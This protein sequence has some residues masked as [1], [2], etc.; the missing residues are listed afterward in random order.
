MTEKFFEQEAAYF[1]CSCGHPVAY[2]KIREPDE[3]DFDDA[4]KKQKCGKCGAE[5]VYDEQH[6]AFKKE[7]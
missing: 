3:V 4:W 5:Y 1:V 2:S 7:E 6:C